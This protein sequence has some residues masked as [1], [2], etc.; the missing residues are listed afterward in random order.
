[1]KNL[2][3][4][5]LAM[6]LGAGCVG[7]PEPWK[8]DTAA[9]ALADSRPRNMDGRGDVGKVE[10]VTPDNVEDVPVDIKT[11]EVVDVVDIALPDT[12]DVALLPDA[13][14]VIAAA[15]VVE[16]VACAPQCEG[17]ECGDNGCG[18][19]CGECGEG[20]E[21]LDNQC[22]CFPV[23][24]G[25]ECGDD[26]CGASCGGCMNN[27]ICE[28]GKCLYSIY[29]IQSSL[30]SQTCADDAFVD[31]GSISLAN[32][33]VA[34]P[35]FELSKDKLHGFFISE[36]QNG[37]YKGALV[38]TAWGDNLEFQVGDIVSLEADWTEYFC[39]T[40]LTA[41][42]VSKT[43]LAQQPGPIVITP[44]DLQPDV[45]EPYEG[46]V[47]RLDDV[48]I[49]S[50]IN[51]YGEFLVTGPET[52]MLKFEG[53]TYQPVLGDHLASISGPVTYSFGKYKIMPR[54]DADI[55]K[56]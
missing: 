28:A 33:N 32:V 36:E 15:E 53:I 8:P 37:Q 43:D 5:G 24:D 39:E 10:T 56:D 35:R 12:A 27:G 31:G 19:S 6:F 47:V 11:G 13:T 29:S 9:D 21:C 1:M 45:G 4:L 22:G 41:K 3:V 44:G 51:A 40:R 46:V 42:M 17:V 50:E 54:S 52:V 14:E 55:Q 25:K 18:G 7:T 16:E 49:L 38:A 34:S 2:I 20:E 26:G 48:E 30:I 23:C